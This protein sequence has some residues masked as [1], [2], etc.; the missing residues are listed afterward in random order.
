MEHTAE[1]REVFTPEEAVEQGALLLDKYRPGWWTT[2]DGAITDG[3]F[4]MDD[5]DSCMVGTLELWARMDDFHPYRMI[6]FNGLSFR[7]SSEQ[8]RWVGFLPLNGEDN[9]DDFDLL[10][11]LWRAQVEKRLRFGTP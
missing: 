1:V 9:N 8:T 10:D 6:G 11:T 5:W 7:A 4:R 2:V 3:L